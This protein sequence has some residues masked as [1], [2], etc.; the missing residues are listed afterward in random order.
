MVEERSSFRTRLTSADAVVNLRKTNLTAAFFH[1]GLL[2]FVL[3]RLFQKGPSTKSPYVCT[4]GGHAINALTCACAETTKKFFESLNVQLLRL[5]TRLPSFM[6]DRLQALIQTDSSLNAC[7]DSIANPEC[8]FWGE[9]STDN[10]LPPV[11]L[12]ILVI[13][14]TAVT[15][16]AHFWYAARY[17][18]YLGMILRG[19]NAWRWIEYG[20]SAS[21]MAVILAVLSGVRLQTSVWMVFVATLVQM[22]QGYLIEHAISSRSVRSAQ[23][24][25]PL[26]VGWLLLVTVWVTIG[27]AW[28]SGLDRATKEIK[29]C[30][31]ESGCNT[32]KQETQEE[33][34]PSESLKWLIVAVIVLFSSFGAVNLAYFINAYA[35][36]P[37]SAQKN[38]PLYEFAY[39]CLSFI[40]KA[41]LI[42][43]VFFSIFAGEL[44]WLQTGGLSSQDTPHTFTS[45]SESICKN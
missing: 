9:I 4:D 36:G 33:A 32:I 3:V 2:V 20:I 10:F 35:Y 44:R 29:K 11:N 12:G 22:L 23:C 6:N 17:E 8:T 27:E 13:T 15:I 38:F 40:S 24:Y 30:K 5:T 43:W 1:I 31:N 34:T 16:I 26:V 45:Y 41:L 7:G 28:F 37:L 19:L 25:V 18:R 42:F 39:I 14:F 21:V